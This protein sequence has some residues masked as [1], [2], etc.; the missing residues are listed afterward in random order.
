MTATELW[1]VRHGR[2]EWAATGRHTGWT[3]IPLDEV[4]RLQATSLAEPLAARVFDQVFSSPLARAHD[5]GALAGFR[6]RA[7]VDDNL[8]E[9]NYGDYEGRT[10]ADILAERPGWMLWDDGVPGGETLDAVAARADRFLGPLR[11]PC[12]RVLI[13]A[14]GHLLRI[15][16]AR[17][18]GL[19]PQAARLFVLDPAATS[20][21]GYE[22][23]Q[24]VI[25][26]W[27]RAADT[28]PRPH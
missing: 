10:K 23:D 13:F 3:D 21:L 27:N 7:V 9:W 1:L 14:H 8:R 16:A 26:T 2:T 6:A 17:W 24:A 18:V 12:G 15:L 4:G 22:R 11:S 25:R 19:D 20:V 28:A 5:T